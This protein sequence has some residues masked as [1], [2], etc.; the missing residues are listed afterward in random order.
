MGNV[1]VQESSLQA[2]AA[3]IRAKNGSANTYTPSQM[4]AAIQAISGGGGSAVLGAKTITVNGTVSAASDSLDGY[5]SVTTNVHPGILEPYVEDLT[6][7]YVDTG[8]WKLG[9]TNCFSDVYEVEANVSYLIALG[10][11]VGTRFRLMFCTDDP[12]ETTENITG[13]S[14]VNLNNPAT[15]A[16]RTYQAPSDGYIIIQKDNAGTANLRTFV[17]ALPDLV[18]GNVVLPHSGVLQPLTV[19]ANGN[20]NPPANVDGFSSAAVNVPTAAS[21]L[22]SKSVTAN[23]EFDP[24]DDGVDGY[25]SLTVDVHPGLITPYAFDLDTGYV[26]NDTWMLGGST[27]NYSDVYQVTAGESYIISLGSAVGSRFR[28]VFTTDDT[29]QA[30][31]DIS[32]TRVVYR[33]NPAARDWVYYKPSSNGYITITKDNAGTAGLKT[34]VYSGSSLALS[35]P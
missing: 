3:A 33:S 13:T 28:A 1:L 11:T 4:A 6:T 31:A 35:N 7:G 17:F 10:D 29:T 23:G 9:G 16:F 22:A 15:Y 27:V 12:S 30:V 24:S 32:G 20:Y 2:I 34:Y 18:D 5:S 8:V 25:S 21:T 26:Y 19:T 14:I